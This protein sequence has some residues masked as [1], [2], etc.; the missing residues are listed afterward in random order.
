MASDCH[1]TFLDE[2]LFLA[3]C[4]VQ[5]TQDMQNGNG[6]CLNNTKGKCSVYFTSSALHASK[7]VVLYE[8]MTVILC[9][10]RHIIFSR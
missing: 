2:L 7:R 5:M 6:G 4:R 3:S 8:Q 10:S 9:N 1:H